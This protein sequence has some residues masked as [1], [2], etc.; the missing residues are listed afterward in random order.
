MCRCFSSPTYS[1]KPV[2]YIGSDVNYETFG[3]IRSPFALLLRPEFI[4]PEVTL[5]G[6]MVRSNP[7]GNLRC[8]DFN[9]QS[10]PASTQDSNC[11]LGKSGNIKA[12][13]VEK[14]WFNQYLDQIIQRRACTSGKMYGELFI[15]QIRVELNN[16]KELKWMNYGTGFLWGS[17]ALDIFNQINK[18]DAKDWFSGYRI[19]TVVPPKL[20]KV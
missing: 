17:S 18:K 15:M 11:W 10:S 13:K 9:F 19:K 6:D 20:A 3:G 8:E 14:H 7:V 1:N 5:P 4:K 12:A 2:W 16:L